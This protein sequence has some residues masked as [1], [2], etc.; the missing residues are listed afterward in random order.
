MTFRAHAI[1]TIGGWGAASAPAS[2]AYGLPGTSQTPSKPSSVPAAA[3]SLVG[4]Q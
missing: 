3:A 2:L 1:G 4:I